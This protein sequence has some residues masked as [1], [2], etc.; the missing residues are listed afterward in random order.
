M[1]REDEQA[2]IDAIRAEQLSR[3]RYE[4]TILKK[5]LAAG[6]PRLRQPKTVVVEF[7]I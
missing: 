5:I 4:K 1:S 7:E 2:R 6:R 3:L